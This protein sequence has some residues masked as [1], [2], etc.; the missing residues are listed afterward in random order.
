MSEERKYQI[1]NSKLSTLKDCFGKYFYNY[2]E[3]KEVQK[4]VFPQTIFGLSLHK[5]L[6]DALTAKKNGSDEKLILKACKNALPDYFNEFLEEKEKQGF[7]FIK[8]REYDSNFITKAEKISIS[9]VKFIFNY[10]KEVHDFKS[11]VEIRTSWNDK[12]D[13][14]GI[15]DLIVWDNEKD[16]RIIDFKTTGDI[17]KFYFVD[18]EKD[19]QS[20]MY[21]FILNKEKK[22]YPKSF[23][24]IVLNKNEKIILIN[25]VKN[26]EKF[27]STH[28]EYL[29]SSIA[30][31]IEK[32]KN[33]SVEFY[34]P[35]PEKCKYCDYNSLCPK[36]DTIATK[37]KRGKK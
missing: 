27:N 5:I 10:F 1:S 17:H 8:T 13:L 24:Y 32:H 21:S 19:M 34:S 36:A 37:M 9:F 28:F 4:K 15:A 26:V 14:M 22:D 29:D 2:I 25:S 7:K 20:L 23:E 12:Y 6:E 33:P 11:E 16:Y 30:E 35:S 3:K 18:W 31:L